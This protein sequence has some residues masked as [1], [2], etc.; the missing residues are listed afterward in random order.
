MELR[1]CKTSGNFHSMVTIRTAELSDIEALTEL[2][3]ELFQIEADFQF[4]AQKQRA[5]L[6]LLLHSDQACVFVAQTIDN[7]KVIAMCSMQTLI[8]TA[9][10]GK[11]GLV[12][13][14]IVNT[15]YRGRGIGKKLLQHLTE[16]AVQHDFKR[17]QLLADKTNASALTFYTQQRWQST[18]LVALRKILS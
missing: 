17:L 10:G 14:V 5:G 3:A 15:A 4:D 18:Q 6:K 13:D 12:E 11:V 8:S 2:L 9:E 7:K 1:D 16:W